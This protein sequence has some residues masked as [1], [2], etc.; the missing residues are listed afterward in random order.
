MLKYWFTAF[1]VCNAFSHKFIQLSFKH[2][3]NIGVNRCS[4]T[5]FSFARCIPWKLVKKHSSWYVASCSGNGRC[6]LLTCHLLD[7]FHSRICNIPNDLGTL[8]FSF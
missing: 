8:L 6:D 5:E 3:N 4:G 7:A 1:L 2:F